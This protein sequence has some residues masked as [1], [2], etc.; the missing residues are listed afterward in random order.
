VGAGDAVGLDERSI[1]DHVSEAA[2]LALL[3][4]LVEIRGLICENV[5][6][7]V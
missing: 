3:Q 7:L 5:N 1:Q 6:A 2:S 4:N